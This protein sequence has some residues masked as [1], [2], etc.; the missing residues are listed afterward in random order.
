VGD[1][2]DKILKAVERV[3]AADAKASDSRRALRNLMRDE[4]AAGRT[5]KSEI[6]RALGVSRQRV[7]R[8]LEE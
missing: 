2:T 4:L 3:R 6:A 5:T 1:S 7:G 8:M